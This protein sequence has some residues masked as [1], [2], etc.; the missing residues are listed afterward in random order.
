M[1][2]AAKRKPMLGMLVISHGRLA[3]ELVAS[4]RTIVGRGEALES[5]EA[6]SIDWDVGV[7][8]ARDRL[9]QAI[10][11]VDG[12]AG[13]LVMT[14]MFGGTSTNLALALH[15]AGR[16]EIVTGV[17]LPMLIKSTD[18][19]AIELGEA[20]TRIAEKGRRTSRTSR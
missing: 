7:D 12:G 19:R 15:E 20:S 18:L 6:L 3:E 1:M 11:R 5:L 10:Q 9:E 13:V 2:A 4:V 8:E 14:D 17:N 16:I